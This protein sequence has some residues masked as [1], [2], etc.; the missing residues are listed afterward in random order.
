MSKFKQGDKVKVVSKPYWIDYNGSQVDVHGVDVGDVFEVY[1][2][3]SQGDV[4]VM[5]T[6]NVSRDFDI[7]EACLE[8]V[9]DS[10]PTDPDHYKRGGIEPIDYIEA[11]VWGE[12]FNRGN[13][14][15]YITRAGYK[16]PATAVEDLEKAKVYIDKEIAR[17]KAKKAGPAEVK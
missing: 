3:D 6:D 12:G 8:L 10:T 1:N 11:Q 14:V 5:D 9:P 15:K 4:H 17:V 2:T 7:N 13:A 16:N